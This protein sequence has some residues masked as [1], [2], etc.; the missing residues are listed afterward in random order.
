MAIINKLVILGGGSAGWMCA[1]YLSKQHP[2][3]DITVVESSKIGS[4]GVGEGSTPHLKT[5]MDT[6][7]ISEQQWM[8]Q[9]DASYKAG[10]Y[11]NNW[12]GDERR[13]FHPF[14]SQMDEKTAEVYCV[15]ANARR[16]GNGDW[17]APDDYFLTG[18]IAKHNLSPKVHTPML[19]EQTY[20]YHFDATKL[21]AVLKA[22]AQEKAVKHIDGEFSQAQLSECGNIVGI[23]LID[24][25]QVNGD[26]FIDASGF[27]ALLIEQTLKTPFNSFANELLND[28]AV[29]VATPVTTDGVIS[30]A[31][32]STALSAGWSWQIPLTSRT[33]NGYVYSSKHI[34]GEQA[35]SELTDQ[36]NIDAQ[37]SAFRHLKMKVGC[38]Q[39][40][41]Q[42]NV[43]AIGLAHSF[44]EPIEATSLMVTQ[45]SIKLFSQALV[46][47][48]NNEQ[49]LA[50]TEHVNQQLHQLVYGIKDYV[51]AHY[52][53]SQRT[54]SSYWLAATQLT[55]SSN[56]LK[57]LLIAWL[58]G[59]DFDVY[60]SKHAQQQVYFRPSWYCLLGG[61]DFKSERCQQVFDPAS[62][63]IN[64]AAKAYLN[65][66]CDQ[67]CEPHAKQLHTMKNQYSTSAKVG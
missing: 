48:Q 10:I 60:L 49:P 55:H 39:S 32:Q 36:L 35:Q 2:K 53:T 44:I 63:A 24:G 21:A 59:D 11:F 51:V 37:N 42:K 3:L 23:T 1:A 5:F 61:M 16:R 47:L 9:C 4:I 29:A 30:C 25:R 19:K 28:S 38:M 40:A 17:Q 41:W 54:N 62:T 66:L 14:Y 57:S 33:G 8:P 43:M 45:H 31:T 7:G 27:N 50:L 22:Y 20:G 26:F 64:N 15:N 13:Y 46:K 67:H 6:L 52:A 65:E 58:N 12:N 18:H 34:T 56:A